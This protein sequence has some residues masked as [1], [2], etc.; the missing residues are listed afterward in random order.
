VRS[1][2]DTAGC[3]AATTASDASDVSIEEGLG[4]VDARVDTRDSH[5]DQPPRQGSRP[6]LKVACE[7]ALISHHELR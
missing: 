7:A 1:V 3:R 6:W 5:P 4:S 2:S